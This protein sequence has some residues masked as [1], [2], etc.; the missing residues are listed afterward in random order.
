MKTK[1]RN[2]P[3]FDRHLIPTAVAL[4]IVVFAMALIFMPSKAVATT[5]S[6]SIPVQ[7]LFSATP[8]VQTDG[9]FNYVISPFV[10]APDFPQQAVH[11]LPAGPVVDTNS[12]A[13]TLTGNETLPLTINFS[14]AGVFGYE[15]RNVGPVAPG[16]SLDPTIYRV[17]VAVSNQPG[18]GLSAE[19]THVLRR[20]ETS[21]AV[22]IDTGPIVFDKSFAALASDPTGKADPPVQKTVQGNPAV[23]YTFTFRLQAQNDGQPMPAGATGNIKD[24]TITGGGS[25]Q[26]GV[27][28][29][30]TAGV[31]SYTV[32]EIASDNSDYVF[33]TTVYTITDTVTSVDGQLV[34]ER[35]VTNNEGARVPIMTFINTFVG[36]EVEVQETP[37]PGAGTG[38]TNRPVVGP[39]TGDYADAASFIAA[40]AI[41]ALIALFAVLLIYLDRRSEREYHDALS[42]AVGIP[43]P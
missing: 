26:F 39:K 33:D 43:S 6:V 13:F 37:P 21:A 34:V 10:D 8:G 22:K 2:T 11:P 29:Y 7:Q 5:T 38:G 14:H 12:V 3:I 40:M 1:M 42:G 25:A 31:F 41:S 4:S 18:G 36:S 24:I 27:W 15:I 23:P 30:S 16:Y 9:V 19:I 28:T 20:T 32:R 35:A 17:R